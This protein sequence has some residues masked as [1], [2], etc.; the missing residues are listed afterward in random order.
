MGGR[1][2]VPHQS[3]AVNVWSCQAVWIASAGACLDAGRGRTSLFNRSPSGEWIQCLHPTLSG[4]M[5][6][7]NAKESVTWQS[8]VTMPFVEH[9]P[10]SFDRLRMTLLVANGSSSVRFPANL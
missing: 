6:T 8:L 5:G 3:E 10:R 2:V 7:S 1:L 4:V 9:R